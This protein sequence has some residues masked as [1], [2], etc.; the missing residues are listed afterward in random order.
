MADEFETCFNLCLIYSK[1][2]KKILLKRCKN[3]KLDGLMVS[4]SSSGINQVEISKLINKELGLE[5]K[6]TRWQIVTTMPQV[7]KKWKID[8][9]LTAADIDSVSK[10]G[11]EL[12]DTSAIPD[13]CHPN[14]KW[15]IPMSIDFTI[16]GS[17]FNQILMK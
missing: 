8:V 6:P 14:L 15:I 1:D 4:S 2:L 10:E 3:G 13:D 5:I 7:E 17:S 16:F 9:Y 12:I 11:F